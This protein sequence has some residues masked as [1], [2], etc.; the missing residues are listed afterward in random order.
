[1]INHAVWKQALGTMER[2]IFE[3]DTK[4]KVTEVRETD[5]VCVY[6]TGLGRHLSGKCCSVRLYSLKE[7]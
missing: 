4:V 2:L 3:Q 7:T 6:K 5:D 1:M